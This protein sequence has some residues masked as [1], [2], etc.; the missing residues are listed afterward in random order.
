MSDKIIASSEKE[1]KLSS[2]SLDVAVVGGGPAGISACL[3]LS[4]QAG[5][6]VALFESEEELGGLPK[7]CHVFF[8]MRD[9]RRLY[10]GPAYTRKLASLIRKTSVQVHTNSTALSLRADPEGNRHYLEVATPGG[11]RHYNCRFILLATG[12]CERPRGARL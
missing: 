6:K 1:S 3:E 10:T 4:R 9:M 5:L 8:G 12:C 11:M 7:S 2:E